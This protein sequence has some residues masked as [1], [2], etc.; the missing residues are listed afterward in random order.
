MVVN[1]GN[2]TRLA[3]DEEIEIE[4]GY[5]RCKSGECTELEILRQQQAQANVPTIVHDSQ[6]AIE[7]AVMAVA[8]GLP[9]ATVPGAAKGRPEL[10]AYAIQPTAG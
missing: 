2:S 3:T 6:P 10:T 9:P 1:E 5:T 4:L 8:T 7:T